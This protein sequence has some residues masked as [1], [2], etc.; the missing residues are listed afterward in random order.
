MKLSYTDGCICTSLTVDDV[1][2]I[3]MPIEELKSVVKTLF[4]R[5]ENEE[6]LQTY[7]LNLITSVGE[8]YLLEYGSGALEEVTVHKVLFKERKD[9]YD[10]FG[11]KSMVYI[12]FTYDDCFVINERKWNFNVT[13]EIRE[14]FHKLIDMTD[15]VAV[16]HEC[17]CASMKS[18]GKYK[19]LG[20]C[21]CCGDYITN[22]TLGI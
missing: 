4:D 9:K 17:W 13:D 1:E 18:Q 11:E 14:M 7:F 22:Y 20:H 5:E 19:D 8:C 10:Y 21:D 15:D 16:L 2:T 6:V 3:D 12:D